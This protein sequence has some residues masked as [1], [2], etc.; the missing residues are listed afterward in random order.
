LHTYGIV[1]AVPGKSLLAEQTVAAAL[2]SILERSSDRLAVW[3]SDRGTAIEEP[4]VGSLLQST[5]LLFPQFAQMRESPST[6]SVSSVDP[7]AAPS[8]TTEPTRWLR[9]H[10]EEQGVLNRSVHSNLL[11]ELLLTSRPQTHLAR[12]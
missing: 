8:R 1:L 5:A 9:G 2:F 6:S 4:V 11:L 12:V 7:L 3:S 10:A